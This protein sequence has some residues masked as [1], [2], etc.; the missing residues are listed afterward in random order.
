MV[1]IFCGMRNMPGYFVPC[2]IHL[3]WHPTGP[4][5]VI[6]RLNPHWQG[7]ERSP[8]PSPSTLVRRVSR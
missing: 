5:Q 1:F 2:H 6:D 7:A 3:L 8:R 4:N